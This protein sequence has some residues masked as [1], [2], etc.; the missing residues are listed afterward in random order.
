[1]EGTPGVETAAVDFANSTATI[2]PG[3]GFDVTAAIAAL[4][5]EGFGAKL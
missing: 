1:M 5:A 4:E 3:A 2:T